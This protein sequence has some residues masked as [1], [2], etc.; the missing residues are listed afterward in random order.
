MNFPSRFPRTRLR[1]L[2]ADD[3]SRRLVRESRVTV[4]DLIE[5]VFVIESQCWCQ[6]GRCRRQC[7]QL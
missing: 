4:D 7:R 2:R 3:F 6:I 1:R 5:P